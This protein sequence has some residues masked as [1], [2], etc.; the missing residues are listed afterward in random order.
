MEEHSTWIAETANRWLGPLIAPAKSALLTVIYGWFGKPYVPG[1]QVIPEHIVFACIVFLACCIF[2]P[3]VRLTFS[4]EKPGKFQQGLELFIEA[5]GSQ[6]ED[7]IGHGGKRFLPM[8]ATIGLFVLL[9]NLSGQIPGF[10]SPTGNINVTAG[11]ALCVFV[12]Y[13]Y[14]GVRKRGFIRYLKHFA[15]PVWWLAPLMMPI[16]FISHLARPFSLTVRLF[17]NI[18]SEHLVVAA[19]FGLIPFLLPLPF[20]VLGLFTAL[21]QAFIFMILPMVYIQGAVAEEH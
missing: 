6:M 11:C 4:V 17:A 14:L 16:E 3:L 2:F 13:N 15:G 1:D 9:M 5:L 19:F 8:V 10:K 12:Y 7:V 21:L 18:F 20:M